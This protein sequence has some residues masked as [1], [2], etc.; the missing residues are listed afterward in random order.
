M[1]KDLYQTLCIIN[2]SSIYNNLKISKHF[3]SISQNLKFIQK[4]NM[5]IYSLY[6]V[7]CVVSYFVTIICNFAPDIVKNQLF[8]VGLV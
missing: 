2:K 6:P 7:P 8:F 3:F 4:Y 1:I 5:I